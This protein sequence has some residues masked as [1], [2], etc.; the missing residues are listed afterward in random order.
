MFQTL[1]SE[2]V[3]AVAFP[4]LMGDRDHLLH[5]SHP[6]LLCNEFPPSIINHTEV[7]CPDSS[8]QLPQPRAPVV[9]GPGPANEDPETEHWSHVLLTEGPGEAGQHRKA[10]GGPSQ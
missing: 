2:D 10:D 8:E 3:G 6:L 1:Q 9:T 7:H 4:C 5:F